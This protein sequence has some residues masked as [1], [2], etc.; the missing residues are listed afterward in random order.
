MPLLLFW[1]IAGLR[2]AF[3]FPMDLAAGWVFRVTGVSVRSVPPQGGDGCCCA[4]G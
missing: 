4:H 3:A 2:A 1:V